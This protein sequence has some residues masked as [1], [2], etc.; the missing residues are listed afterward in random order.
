M[1]FSPLQLQFF[2]PSLVPSKGNTELTLF[3]YGFTD[4]EYKSARFKINSNVIAEVDIF[5][6]VK[7]SSFYC[8]TPEF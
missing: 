5:Y 7:T 3:G 1:L 2:K 8:K 6:D 4:S